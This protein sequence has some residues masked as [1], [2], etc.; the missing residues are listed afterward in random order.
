M[1]PKIA[2]R[3]KNP[4]L[5]KYVFGMLQMESKK[6]HSETIS[7]RRNNKKSIIQ[8]HPRAAD[9]DYIW[10]FKVFRIS[11]FSNATSRAKFDVGKHLP[12]CF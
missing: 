7:N 12:I 9:G 3:C 4:K 10:L 2:P 5:A 6:I 11:L 8:L 1:L